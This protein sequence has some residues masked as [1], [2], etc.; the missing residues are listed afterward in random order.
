ME[1][2]SP[3]YELLYRCEGMGMRLQREWDLIPEVAILQA[4]RVFLEEDR[5][6]NQ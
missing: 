5:V 1:F 3:V 6:Q 2:H 4:C